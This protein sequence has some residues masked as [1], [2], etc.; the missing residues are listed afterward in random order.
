M[1]YRQGNTHKDSHFTYPKQG[2]GDLHHMETKK[3]DGVDTFDE[4]CQRDVNIVLS[5]GNTIGIET[6]YER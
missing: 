6:D 1:H 5:M 4:K 2:K 3:K